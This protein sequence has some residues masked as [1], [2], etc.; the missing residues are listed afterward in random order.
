MNGIHLPRGRFTDALVAFTL[1]I[2]VLQVLGAVQA[3][4]SHYA[5]SPILFL[6]DG[7]RDPPTWLSPIVS[8]FLLPSIMT[9]LFNTVL[10][11]IAGRYVEQALGGAGMLLAFIAGAYGGALARLVLTPN[12]IFFT[13]GADAGLFALIGAYLS[14]YGVPKM[15]PVAPHYSRGAQIAV[16]AG[17]WA[18]VQLA[19]MLAGGSFELSVSLINP[20]A[21]LA[22]GALLARPLLRFRYRRA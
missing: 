22:T 19:F 20:L 6:A 11:L 1:F 16:V 5:F 13:A 10:L 21:G 3:A 9:V 18:A 15:V 8:Q 7:W 2:S 4:L 12:S 17:I 14:L